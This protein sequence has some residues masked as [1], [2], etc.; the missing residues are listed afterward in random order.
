MVID[1][2]KMLSVALI[3][4][5]A[6]VLIAGVV[7]YA[8]IQLEPGEPLPASL[9]IALSVGFGLIMV[10]ISYIISMD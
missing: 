8:A 4:F 10:G 5:W 3:F 9:L 2:R 1:K 6:G 7:V